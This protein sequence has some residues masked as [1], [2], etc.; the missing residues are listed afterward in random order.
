MRHTVFVVFLV[1]TRITGCIL[2]FVSLL[3]TLVEHLFEEIELGFYTR[4]E[5]EY[6]G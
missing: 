2:G 3:S 6:G 4:R 1:P 5:E